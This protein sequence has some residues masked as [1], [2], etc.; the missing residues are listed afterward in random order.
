MSKIKTLTCAAILSGIFLTPVLTSAAEP[1]AK[2]KTTP[3]KPYPMTTCVVSDEKL[4]EM[5]DPYVHQYK[6]REVKLCCKSCLKEFNAQPAKFIKKLDQ[7]AA[8]ASGVK[9]YPLNVC[10]ISDEKLDSMGEPF[11]F[12]YKDQ[13]VKFCCEGC[14][15]DFN[16]QPAKFIKKMEDAA[17]KTT[18]K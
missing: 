12:K 5:G 8:K 2:A 6:G 18:N 9:A 15:K 10:L 14:L 7:A 13:E 16:K 11:V 3:A 17:R 4:G 1:E